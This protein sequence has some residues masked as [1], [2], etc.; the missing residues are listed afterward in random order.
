MSKRDELLALLAEDPLG[1]LKEERERAGSAAQDSALVTS[2]EEILAFCEEHGREPESN[3]ANINEFRLHSRLG[4]IRADPGK[5]RALKP[6]DL[7]GLLKGEGVKEISVE[8]V[9]SDDPYGLLA[10][11]EET[12]IHTLK[13]VKPVERI[14]PDHLARKKVCRDFGQFKDM[15]DVLQRELAAQKRRL[16]RYTVSDLGVG[17]FY[18]LRGVL[19]YIRSIDGKVDTS[20]FESGWRERFDGRTVCVFDNG[21][22]SDMLFRSLDKAMQIDGYSISEPTETGGGEAVAGEEDVTHGFIYVLKS[23]NHHVRGLQDVHKIGH[24]TG[25]VDHRLRNAKQQATY[26]FADVEVAVTFRCLNVDSHDLERTIHDFFEDVKL[27]IELTDHNGQ[28]YK[29]KEWFKVGLKV[30]KDAIKLIL[31]NKVNDYYYDDRIRQIVKR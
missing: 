20:H 19:L 29:P 1:L 9:I 17:G 31:D 16:K 30:I 11:D 25:L 24:T 7:K 13:H 12:D 2:F 15:F 23:L 22:E 21:T 28:V 5:V 8:D 27:D 6:Y 14:S 3:M 4:A 10:D 26:L 18:V